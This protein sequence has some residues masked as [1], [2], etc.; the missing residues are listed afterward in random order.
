MYWNR[1]ETK[2]YV[3]DKKCMDRNCKGLVP[4]YIVMAK[5]SKAIPCVGEESQCAALKSCGM[6][7][8][9][10]EEH[11]KGVANRRGA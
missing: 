11:C 10:T 4:I 2:R 3:T 9:G 1:V 8:C 6:A 7:T 5:Y